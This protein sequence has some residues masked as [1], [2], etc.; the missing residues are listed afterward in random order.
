MRIR[1]VRPVTTKNPKPIWFEGLFAVARAGTEVT[2]VSLDKG[3]SSAESMRGFNVKQRNRHICG[4][5]TASASKKR[6]RASIYSR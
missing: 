3:P 2:A 1:I 5:A 4:G 6:R